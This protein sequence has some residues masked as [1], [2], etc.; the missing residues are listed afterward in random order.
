[1]ANVTAD[2]AAEG[3]A[4]TPRP[5]VRPARPRAGRGWTRAAAA[6]S[7]LALLPVV[8]LLWQALAGSSGLWPHLR[9]HVLPQA[10]HDTAI[11]LVG[12]GVLVTAIGTSAAWLVTAYDFPGRR[13]FSWALLLP[14]AMPSYIIAYAYLDLLHPIGSLQTGLRGVLGYDSP[15]DFRLPDIRSMAGCILLLSLVLYPYVYI[16][17]RALFLSQ[18]ANLIDASRT[19]GTSRAAVFRRVA[20]PLARPAIAVGASLAL[21][22]A[23]ND[24][25]AAEFLGVRTLTVSIYSTWVTRSDLAGAA[26]IAL[27]MLVM[28]LALILAER[29]ARRNVRY[30]GSAMRSIPLGP[31][32]LTGL[33]GW[34]ALGLVALP[35]ALGFAAPAG[36]LVHA[37]LSRLGAGP[38]LG[39]LWRAGASTVALAAAATAATVGLGLV[40]A[41]AA[42][43]RPGRGAETA[44]RLSTIGYAMPGTVVALG[45]LMPVAAFDGLFDRGIA[46][47]TGTRPGM[48][49]LGSGAALVLAYVV[50]FLSISAGTIEAGFTRLPRSYDGAARS[51]GR[52]PTGLMGQIH[53]PLLRAPLVAGALLVFVD[54]VKELPATLMLRP[55][56][57]ET[58]ATQLY[59][60]A[61]R[62]TY[63]N[64]ALAA[65]A[66]LA[67]GLLPAILLARTGER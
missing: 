23:L 20:L 53:L 26:Q 39:A 19:L 7:M 2:L 4:A 61:S 24:V 18:A 29:W 3:F 63:E 52:S 51:L 42:R 13:V 50:R 67:V 45:L 27:A 14:L 35:V 30:A 10:L 66:I 64:G 22:E 54:C 34:T 9:A 37:A 12:V 59:A 46:S 36:Y 16:P 38:D 6:I 32:R 48:I 31:R 58:L 56:G 60:E 33:A 25:G 65:L 17:V 28:V 11:L 40:V 15:R 62:G 21:M 1:M 8:A 49:L 55:L 5:H 57:V 44:L 47:L 43:L 41:A